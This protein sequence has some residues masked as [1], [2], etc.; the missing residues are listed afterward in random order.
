MN[1]RI[2]ADAISKSPISYWKLAILLISFFRYGI[3][4]HRIS[5]LCRSESQKST[6]LRSHTYRGSMLEFLNVYIILYLAVYIILYLDIMM[7]IRA[8]YT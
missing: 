1:T 8:I 7:N 4:I 5:L 2:N 6:M 3:T